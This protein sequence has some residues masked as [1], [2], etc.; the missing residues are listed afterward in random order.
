MSNAVSII[1]L[2]LVIL[3]LAFFVFRGF[4]KG[5]LKVALTTFSFVI[6]IILATALA[7]PV[8]NLLARTSFGESVESSVESMVDE[9]FAGAA[10]EEGLT[11]EEESALLDTLPLPSFIQDTILNSGTA[12]EY[13]DL[14]VTSFKEYT[15]AKV[16][17][18]ILSAISYVI[19]MIAA[20]IIIRLILKF[21]GFINKIPVLGGLNKFL[22][23]L[24]GLFEGLLIIWAIGL[25]II[26]LSS[27]SFGIKAIEI[28]QGS[29]FLNFL[30]ENNLLIVFFG[31]LF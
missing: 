31:M 29:T 27:T 30:F 25:L 28:I 6:V 1:V 13:T 7:K 11:S 12:E 26:A 4:R 14:G 24:L 21:A 10:E 2:I 15:T 22:G 20:Y 8:S 17:Q 3:F 5:F 19:V 18:I 9:K 23:A 16:T